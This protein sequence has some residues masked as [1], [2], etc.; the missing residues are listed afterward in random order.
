[1]ESFVAISDGQTYNFLHTEV[2]YNCAIENICYLY[3][4]YMKIYIHKWDQKLKSM[5][6]K[7]RNHKI[8]TTENKA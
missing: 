1:M 3:Q 7:E 2:L 4:N 5:A 6:D 8:G